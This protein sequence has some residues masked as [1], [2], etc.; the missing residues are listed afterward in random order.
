MALMGLF[1]LGLFPEGYARSGL[2]G[3]VLDAGPITALLREPYLGIQMRVRVPPERAVGLLPPS[4][5]HRPNMSR[6]LA[7]GCREQLP[8]KNQRPAVVCNEELRDS[9][10]T[11][12]SHFSNS[13]DLAPALEWQAGGSLT[14]GAGGTQC[15]IANRC[16]NCVSE[17]LRTF[18]EATRSSQHSSSL[19]SGRV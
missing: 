17:A 4:G 13:S 6:Y 16:Q 3:E 1:R 18:Y 5:S 19:G 9:A 15:A 7:R 10:R 11:M 2:L 14:Q 12:R 8:V